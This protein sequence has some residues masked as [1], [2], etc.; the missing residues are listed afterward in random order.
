MHFCSKDKK[1][2]VKFQQRMA[3]EQKIIYV[4]QD[5]DKEVWHFWSAVNKK[6]RTGR[7]KN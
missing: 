6:R 4:Y 7:W 3:D 2:M 5:W 1:N